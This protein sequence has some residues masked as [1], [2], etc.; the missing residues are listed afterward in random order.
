MRRIDEARRAGTLDIAFEQ[1]GDFDD[2]DRE[3]HVRVISASS[4][5]VWGFLQRP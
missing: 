1:I 5:G 3:L 4:G 2:A